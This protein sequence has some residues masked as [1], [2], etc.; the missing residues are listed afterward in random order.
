MKD[1]PTK[2]DWLLL[3]LIAI[4]VVIQGL[5]EVNPNH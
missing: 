2:R 1:K 3:I 5:L 4:A